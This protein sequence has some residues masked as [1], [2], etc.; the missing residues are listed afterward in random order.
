MIEALVFLIA[1]TPICI[2][3]AQSDLR[4]MIIP[5]WVSLALVA[6]F[7]VLG[8]IFLPINVIGW[9]LLGGFIVLA[10]GFV[11][12]AFGFVGGGDVKFLA[13]LAP[14]VTHREIPPFLLILSACMLVTLALHRIAARI[15]AV[16]RA[17]PNWKSWSAG[18][19]FPLGISIALAGI[20]YLAMRVVNAG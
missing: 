7:C 6:V 20:I 2:F 14:F 12:N 3:A 10:V 1:V 4:F 19:H 5:N 9:Q 11:L 17:T 16:R 18:R 13:G 8:L 15:P